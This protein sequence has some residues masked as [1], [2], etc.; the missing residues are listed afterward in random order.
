[1][2]QGTTPSQTI[3]PFFHYA[4]P[5]EGLN[6][7]TKAAPQGEKILIEGRVVDGDGAPV[8][9]ALIEIWQANAAGKY[10][11]DEDSQDKS[12]DPGFIGFGR[13][14]TDE[15]GIYRFTTIRPGSVT[16]PDG[17]AQAPHIE[18]SIFARG[19][20][21]RLV[22][23]IYFADEPANERDPV[24]TSIADAAVRESLLAQPRNG[25]TPKSYR[26]DIVLQGEGETAFFDL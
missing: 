19:L 17:T 25:G 22:T 18:V 4:L 11:H 21:K 13:C 6:D 3:G 5:R 7:L 26:F 23:R 8:V 12:V 2:K 1:M 24:L 16:G 10:A 15:E 9:D 20:L 14:A